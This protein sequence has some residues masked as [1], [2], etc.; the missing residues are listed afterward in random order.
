MKA[1]L[2]IIILFSCFNLEA[3]IKLP[4]E[5]EWKSNIFNTSPICPLE[6][7]KGKIRY[8]ANLDIYVRTDSTGKKVVQDSGYYG[9]GCWYDEHNNILTETQFI[10][11]KERIYSRNTYDDKL[12]LIRTDNVKFGE[13]EDSIIY[14]DVENTITRYQNKGRREPKLVVY[15]FD[16]SGSLIKMAKQYPWEAN[17]NFEYIYEYDNQKRLT[18][19]I[20]KNVGG[21]RMR[22]TF[23]KDTTAHLV[24]SD[25]MIYEYIDKENMEIVRKYRQ[26]NG[27]KLLKEE[28]IVYFKDQT[29]VFRKY[30]GPDDTVTDSIFVSDTD[31]LVV[32]DT[33]SVIYRLEGYEGKISSITH[34]DKNNRIDTFFYPE[35]PLDKT[36]YKYKL[37]NKG[38]WI[39]QQ[40]FEDGQLFH[41]RKRIIE[42]FE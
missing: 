20:Y 16:K 17:I 14:N 23:G 29:K 37:D 31:S 10:K 6:I 22:N 27:L 39:E 13:T 33:G 9:R 30:A 18:R 34:F 42:Y 11:G 24:R 21:I 12:R 2:A 15:Y 26:M 5:P 36:I 41:V 7:L 19:E 3:Q 4:V 35:W 25:T 8:I 40:V 28:S 32:S 38:N 1:L